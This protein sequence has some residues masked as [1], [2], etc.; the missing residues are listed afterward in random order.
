MTT[1]DFQLERDAFGRLNL[2]DAAG[3]VHHNVSPV[4][5]FPVQA[6]DEGLALVNGDGKEVAWIDRLDD[7][8]PAVAGL[9]REE[10]SG[11]EFMPEIAR[12]IDVTSFATPCTW[13]VETNRG[14]TE[15]VLRGE[16]DIRRIGPEALLVSDTH[17]IHF[18]IRDQYALDKHS[19]KILDRFM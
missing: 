4:R 19:K 9:V 6:P 3:T 11:R 1:I 12:I 8:P 16:E 5:A 7:L 10:L 2:T 15:F 14:R 18:L 17:G 13:T